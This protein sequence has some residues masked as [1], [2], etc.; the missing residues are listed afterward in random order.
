MYSSAAP[1]AA[2][3][4]ASGGSNIANLY[5][6][7]GQGIAGLQ[8]GQG[9]KVSDILTGNTGAQAST[10]L[11]TGQNLANLANGDYGSLANLGYQTATGQGNAQANAEL[12]KYQASQNALNFGMNIA[13]MAAS[14]ATGVPT[15]GGGNPFSSGA[16]GYSGQGPF[17]NGTPSGSSNGFGSGFGSWANSFMPWG[18]GSTA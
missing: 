9:N 2:S 1:T 16:G 7:G 11:G 4:L 10:Q 6:Q 18:N 13:K 17:I 8:V 15:G 3:L 12:A 5:A 14:A